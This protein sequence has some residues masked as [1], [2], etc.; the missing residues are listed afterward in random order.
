M[1]VAPKGGEPATIASLTVPVE[2]LRRF[3]GEQDLHSR[4]SQ[5]R[6]RYPAVRFDP[7]LAAER[8]GRPYRPTLRILRS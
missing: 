2:T 6:D 5:R 8:H 4:L 1:V 7:V 3:A